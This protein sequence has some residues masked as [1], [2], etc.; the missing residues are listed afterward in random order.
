MMFHPLRKKDFNHS[1]LPKSL[2]NKRCLSQGSINEKIQIVFIIRFNTFEIGT[3]SE[4]V[5]I[6]YTVAQQVQTD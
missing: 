3:L 6:E 1:H 4:E 5:K 2:C